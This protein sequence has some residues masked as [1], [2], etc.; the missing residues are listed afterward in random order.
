MKR[1]VSNVVTKQSAYP[2]IKMTA[3]DASVTMVT[4]ENHAVSLELRFTFL[5]ANYSIENLFYSNFLIEKS[6]LF[7]SYQNQ[8]AASSCFKMVS[9][10]VAC[11]PSIQMAANQYKC[12]VT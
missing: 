9:I 8:K 7:S 11:T 1:T 6:F 2:T 3:Y 5:D 12:C 10:P 4:Q